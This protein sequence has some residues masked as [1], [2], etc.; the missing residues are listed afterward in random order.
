MGGNK[1]KLLQMGATI[2]ILGG[3]QLARMLAMAAAKLGLRTVI[4][5]PEEERPAA[6][7][8]DRH[9]IA[10]YN[11]ATALRKFAAAVDVA[12]YEFENI[13]SAYLDVLSKC[14]P[15][16][17]NAKALRI[18]QN[19]LLEK[20][21][22]TKHDLPVAPYCPI[23]NLEQLEKALASFGERSLLKT[24]QLGYDG[25]GQ[26]N[27][28]KLGI[29]GAK[30]A[31]IEGGSCPSILESFVD[32]TQE[33]SIIVARDIYG[34]LAFY[35]MPQNIHKNGILHRSVVPA[36]LSSSTVTKAQKIAE[37]VTTLLDYTGVLVIEFFVL[38]GEKLL[39]NEMA[40]R[41]HNSGHWTMDACITSQFEQHIRAISG[42]FLG[43]T[44]RHSDC[45]MYN[46]LGAAVEGFESL[47]QQ[48]Q[49]SLHLYGKKIV[50]P[51]RKMGHFT[52]LKHKS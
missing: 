33:V 5:C 20:D 31:F 36:K 47:L 11:D 44:T 18:A 6:S 13:P 9:I 41:V 49:L 48:P 24:R 26:I 27:V 28:E 52:I 21:F 34:T 50:R 19:R 25:H 14:V 17:F 45:E 51:E 4:F 1:K 42:L 16:L 15:N 8:V 10:D 32:F 23:D 2:G 43:G 39:I 29:E 22:F 46:L 12:T 7:L 3:G 37:K 35:D 40:P 38:Q 30:K